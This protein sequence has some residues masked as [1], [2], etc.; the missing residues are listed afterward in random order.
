MRFVV[1][2]SG[3]KGNALLVEGG[4]VKVLV[5]C[6]LTPKALR[7]RLYEAGRALT[8]LDALLVTHGHGDHVKGA[9]RL[10]G[11]LRLRTYAT[12]QTARFL[13][14]GGGLTNHVPISQDA[15]FQ[16]GRLSVHA[17]ATPHDAPGSVGYVLDD[18]HAR[19]GIC[20][21]LGHP[22]PAVARAL[23]G[24]DTLYLEFNH[25]RDMLQRGP[26]PPALKRRITSGRGHLSNEQAAELLELARTPRLTRL[27]LAHLSETNNTPR[28][29]LDAA[30]A[31]VDER[32]VEMIVAPQ[33]A[34]SRWFQ[35]REG[36]A[37]AATPP[38]RASVRPAD[39]VPPIRYGSTGLAPP[40]RAPA[41]L[42]SGP[43]RQRSVAV[44]SVAVT[45]QLGL[46]GGGTDAGDPG[47][48]R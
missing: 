38:E 42:R 48:E 17:F 40:A 12:A 34:P 31:V 14:R 24:C 22:D 30:R 11:A 46:F 23:E 32:D 41:S 47:D 29:A 6:G 7:S 26:Y 10:A 21:D 25:D 2:A 3:S 35:V 1:L 45:R 16:V 8:D 33:H 28:L 18:G 36:G 27:L 37:P 39:K 43:V 4:G 13:A 15:R 20:T 19:L 9:G 5:D 44:T